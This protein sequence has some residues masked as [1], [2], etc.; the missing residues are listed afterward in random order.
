MKKPDT[1]GQVL[2]IRVL[3]REAPV[4]AKVESQDGGS[5]G[6]GQGLPVVNEIWH[7]LEMMNKFGTWTEVMTTCVEFV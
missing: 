4:H 6:Q 7:L 1:K 5:Q 3:L 2:T